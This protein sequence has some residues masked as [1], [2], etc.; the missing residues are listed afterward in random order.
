MATTGTQTVSDI[1]THALRI[2]GVSAIDE[3]VT[4][5]AMDIAIRELEN[6]LK[7]WQAKRYLTWTYTAGSLALTTAASY[8]LSPARP[9][10][11]LSARFN[12]GSTE[13]PMVEMTR[14]EYDE[15]PNKT[16]TGTP[17]QFHWDKSKETGTFYVWPVLSAAS[18]QTV[19]FTYERELEDIAGP[20]DVIDVPGEWWDAVAYNL[21]SRMQIAFKISDQRVDGMAAYALSEV[22]ADDM[23]GSVYF[24][25]QSYRANHVAYN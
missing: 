16:A 10:R 21:A 18:G 22:L 8:T 17:T 14:A 9:Y 12:G 6:M 19:E 25:D 2:A 7:A 1:C 20:S 5:E 15:L 3:P 24:T 11:I 4:S 13:I 23:E